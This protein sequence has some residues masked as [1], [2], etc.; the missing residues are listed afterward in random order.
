MKKLVL[1]AIALMGVLSASAQNRLERVEYQESSA[2][3]IEPQ[4]SVMIAPL[5][6]DL[7]ILSGKISY[8]EVEAFKN[9]EVTPAIVQYI[10]DFK[11]VA[12]SRAARK[13][14][15][16][17]IVGA[18][19]DV[20]TNSLGRIEITISGY[21]ARYTNFR[22]ATAQDVS[23]VGAAKVVCDDN[24]GILNSAESRTDITIQK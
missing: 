15:A 24:V 9:Y 20:V 19:V 2:R 10:P 3:N 21:P 5:I 6:A 7:Q 23:L 22:N 8:T 4:Q 11:K 16:D 13:Y 1:C 18:T 12:L 17:V 14:E